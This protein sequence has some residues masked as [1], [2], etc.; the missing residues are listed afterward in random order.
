MKGVGPDRVRLGRIAK[1]SSWYDS[2]DF[3]LAALLCDNAK[4]PGDSGDR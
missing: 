3:Y 2:R 4:F 1:K